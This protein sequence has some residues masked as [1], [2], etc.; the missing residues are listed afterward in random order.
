MMAQLARHAIKGATD[1]EVWDIVRNEQ[2]TNDYPGIT[3][4]KEDRYG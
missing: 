3:S 2:K 1:A 4:L